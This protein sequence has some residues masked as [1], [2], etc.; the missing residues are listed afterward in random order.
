M[1]NDISEFRPCCL[2]KF[3]DKVLSQRIIEVN[4]EYCERFLMR[5]SWLGIR[6]VFTIDMHNDW[7]EKKSEQLKNTGKFFWKNI[8]NIYSLIIDRN[9][10]AWTFSMNM[11]LLLQITC[12]FHRIIAN[13]IIYIYIYITCNYYPFIFCKIYYHQYL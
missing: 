8:F 7:G 5:V 11:F 10:Q 2:Y 9:I 4:R 6:L 13:A 12:A 1:P 3:V